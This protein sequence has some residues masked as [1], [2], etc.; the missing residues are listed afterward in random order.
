[1]SMSK[2]RPEVIQQVTSQTPPTVN[3]HVTLENIT[4]VSRILAIIF[5]GGAVLAIAAYLAHIGLGQHVASV[6]TMASL[7]SFGYWARRRAD[8]VEFRFGPFS[9]IAV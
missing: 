5:A 9:K 1:L 8:Q 6:V 2:P 3:Q 4:P 7:I